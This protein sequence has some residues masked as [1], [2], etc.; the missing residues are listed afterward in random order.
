MRSI[1]IMII[2]IVGFGLARPA[3]ANCVVIAQLDEM[4]ALQSNLARGPNPVLFSDQIRRLRTLSA[5]TTPPDV[6]RAVSGNRWVGQ[7]A[8]FARFLDHT[9][10]LLQRAS[11]DDPSSVQSHF[12]GGAAQNLQ[13]VGGYLNGLRCTGAQIAAA[14]ASQSTSSSLDDAFASVSPQRTLV[15]AAVLLLMIA[16]L[17]LIFRRRILLQRKRAKR[18]RL[19][20]RTRYWW[21]NRLVNVTLLDINR[22]GTRLRHQ[23]GRALPK[24]ADVDIA[25]ANDWATGTIVWSDAND[26]GVKFKNELSWPAVGLLCASVEVKM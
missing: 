25:L 1:G 4:H 2:L 19:A 15:V 24:G 23:G 13:R 14:R 6:Q 26:S 22:N 21:D 17:R 11:L 10:I 7:G 16:A 8:V 3:V 12:V 9:K 20:Y 18:H 5:A